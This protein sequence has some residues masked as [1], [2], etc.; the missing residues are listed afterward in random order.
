VPP[1]LAALIRSP[2]SLSLRSPAPPVNPQLLLIPFGPEDEAG[3]AVVVVG[4]G[5]VALG[6]CRDAESE[7]LLVPADEDGRDGV[8]DDGGA[9]LTTAGLLPAWAA[10]ADSLLSPSLVL[11]REDVD[12]LSEED[13]FLTSSDSSRLRAGKLGFLGFSMT[14]FATIPI[15]GLSFLRGTS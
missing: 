11:L 15:P 12:M 2:F 1:L 4:A 5:G 7:L 9:N 3:R 10:P 6:A 8:G 14:Q 13:D